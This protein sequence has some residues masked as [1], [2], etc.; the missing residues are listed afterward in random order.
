MNCLHIHTITKVNNDMQV[1]IV[2][3]YKTLTYMHN[4]VKKADNFM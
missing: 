3:T 4:K 1:I 2:V